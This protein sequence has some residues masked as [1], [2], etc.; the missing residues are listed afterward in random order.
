M[1][2]RIFHLFALIVL[3]VTLP[4]SALRA[5]DATKPAAGPAV[6]HFFA[7]DAIDLGAILPVPPASGSL[8]AQADLEAVL[9]AQAWRTPEQVAWAKLVAAADM[10]P[11]YATGVPFGPWFTR[12]NLPSLA[13]LFKDEGEDWSA[14]R[15]SK[16]DKTLYPRM[17]P[18]LVDARVQPCVNRPD[19]G[20]YPSSHAIL[21]FVWAGV[22]SEIFPEKRTEL[23]DCA[24]RAAWG[25]V[26]GGV[27]FPSDLVG[28]RVAAAAIVAQLKKSAAFQAAVE[29]CRA[30]A[31]PFLPKKA[32]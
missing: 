23:F 27:H 2:R 26:L 30:E 29:K 7:P 31:Q 9:Q 17:R 22:L 32:A 6:P 14:C 24:H 11:V 15:W 25:R 8:A 20:S 4:G 13:Q 5:A 19:S 18:F 12:E 21:A 28:G 16:A 10:F 1:N 3:S